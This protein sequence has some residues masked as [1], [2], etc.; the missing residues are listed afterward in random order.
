[1][2][3]LT[4]GSFSWHLR[5]SIGWW[6]DY[7]L[8]ERFEDFDE[9][10]HSRYFPVEALFLWVQDSGGV[11]PEEFATEPD[12]YLDDNGNILP[13]DVK[14]SLSKIEQLAVYGLWLIDEDLGSPGPSTED[15]WDENRRNVNG[16]AEVDVVKHKA[17]CLLLAYQ[18]LSYIQRLQHNPQI[19][20]DEIDIAEQVNTALKKARSEQASRAA[21]AKHA[22]DSKQAAKKCVFE[23]WER[24]Q[25][26]HKN[27]DG[28]AEFARDMLDKYPELTSQKKIEDWCRDWKR[29]AKE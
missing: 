9:D 5:K 8:V 20:A 3:V 14:P 24:W 25:N 23:C 19:T 16:W 4:R 26:N 2:R 11:L 28:Q 27:Y 6:L 7:W 10:C 21:I 12:K 13:T 1:M 22:K 29:A 17:E 18:C 15:D